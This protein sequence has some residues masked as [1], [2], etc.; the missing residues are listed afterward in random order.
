MAVVAIG[1]RPNVTLAK[2]TGLKIGNLGGIDVNEYMQTSDPDIY[3]V[4]DCV[5]TVNR[6]TGK[7]C[8]RPTAI[9]QTSRVEWLVKTP[10]RKIA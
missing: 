10:P 7:R 1:V 6:I 3:A 9:W 4:G 5:E 8:L 2:D